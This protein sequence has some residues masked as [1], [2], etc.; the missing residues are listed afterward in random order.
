MVA[1]MEPVKISRFFTWPSS[2]AITAST[3]RSLIKSSKPAETA[4][5]ACDGLRPVAKALGEAS[6]NTHSF[7]IGIPMRS[8][9]CA[10]MGPIRVKIAAFSV[11]LTRTAPL[12]E[13]AIFSE[14]K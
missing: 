6:G 11:S 13:S 9:N 1:A 7:G 2:W 8:H 12:E 3:S 10:V 5:D 4:T 14:K